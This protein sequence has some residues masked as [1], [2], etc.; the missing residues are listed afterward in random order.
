MPG[1]LL[2][3]G[4][5]HRTA[6]IG[7]RERLAVE[8]ERAA[9]MAA[10]LI[11]EPGLEEA[12]VL[13]TCGRTELYALASEPEEA[14]RRLTASLASH[15]GC[16]PEE[17]A[18]GVRT[19]RGYAVV[20]HLHRVAAGLDSMAL[21]EVEILGQLRRA[22]ALASAAG[23]RGRILE[24]LVE[25]SLATGRRVRHETDIGGG[26]AS[27]ASAAVGI[28]SR[29]LRPDMDGSA[30]VI[31]S[32]NTGAKTARALGAAGLGVTVVAGRRRE[33]ASR[34]ASELGR[35]VAGLDD[36]P[37]LLSEVDLVVSCTSAP[38]QLVSAEVLV[39]A[40]QRRSGRE[41]VAIDLAVPRDFDPAARA[42][43]GVRLYDLDDLEGELRF[44]AGR[45]S[46]AI[47]AAAA[48][49]AGEVERF[50]HWTAALSVV[51]TI[52]DLRARSKGAV[53]EALRR[54]DLAADAD[55]DLLRS[56]SEAIVTRLL[57]SPTA[58]LREAAAQGDADRV[59][60]VV[61]ELFALDA[62]PSPASN[63]ELRY[64]T[65]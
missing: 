18:P 19:A 32:G 23:P 43:E 41:L 64:A 42:V 44:T 1:E 25:S 14:E 3:V 28:A 54:S 21:G 52:K 49:I 60:H 24:R 6:P 56:T 47:P 34:L 45:R 9:E 8:P 35:P 58:Q 50:M 59:T 29:H 31:G 26:R 16:R 7:L 51:P 39:D 30:L 17:L 37:R 57:H 12:L 61:R 15:A 62:V 22:S 11:A 40:V 36:L 33:R 10:E 20:A 4:A 63:V 55:E 46:A 5:S 27:I 48:I 53:L 2:L 13:A 65:T 38:H